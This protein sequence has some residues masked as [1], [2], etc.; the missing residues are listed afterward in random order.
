PPAALCKSYPT[1]GTV[2]KPPIKLCD[3]TVWVVLG[4]WH[5][6]KTSRVYYLEF[7]FAFDA[8]QKERIGNRF[9]NVPVTCKLSSKRVAT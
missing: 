4:R 7:L 3:R 5:D 1:I 6:E 8:N 2:C 9:M